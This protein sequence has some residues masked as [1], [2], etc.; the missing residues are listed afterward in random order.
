M[1]DTLTTPLSLSTI[2]ESAPG[3]EAMPVG[4]QVICRRIEPSDSLADIYNG[5]LGKVVSHTAGGTPKV[6]FD[7]THAGTRTW[8]INAWT[9]LPPRGHMVTVTDVLEG[10]TQEFREHMIGKTVPFYDA[11]QRGASIGVRVTGH[12][13][14]DCPDAVLV[15]GVTWTPTTPGE[16]LGD[17]LVAT[18]EAQVAEVV[19][20]S[21]VE[22]ERKAQA[23]LAALVEGINEL[24]EQQEWCGEF[25]SWA[26]RNNVE[27]TRSCEKE[28]R[29][30]LTLTYTV[31]I[32][33]D[34]I[35]EAFED[36][37]GGEH[38]NTD[39]DGVDAE[40]RSTVTI[41]VTSSTEP[42]EMDSWEIEERLRSDDYDGWD[43]WTIDDWNEQ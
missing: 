31:S 16:A 38:G 13:F 39:T 4:T 5:R 23:T 9:P 34:K 21:R 12:G 10:A 24:A 2:I 18:A 15:T 29:I 1:S 37:F 26:E 19:V 6:E 36:Q 8:W 32:S 43:D 42:G 28:Y 3:V 25:E 17:A 33:D 30:D 35:A 20:E 11:E 40:V 22:R 14:P 27:V 41:Y 7:V